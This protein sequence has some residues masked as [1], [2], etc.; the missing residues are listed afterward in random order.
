MGAPAPSVLE[1]FP[2]PERI[3]DLEVFVVAHL[4]V[5]GAGVVPQGLRRRDETP[6]PVAGLARRGAHREEA[7]VFFAVAAQ[8]QEFCYGGEGE[9]CPA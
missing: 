7:C 4:R 3:L 6:G 5:E 8:S 2:G 9:P 1:L